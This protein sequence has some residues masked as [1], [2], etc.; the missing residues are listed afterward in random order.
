M[1]VVGHEDALALA[2][3]DD[4]VGA[5]GQRA[6]VGNEDAR[7]APTEGLA[8]IGN[9]ELGIAQ[10]EFGAISDRNTVKVGPGGIL[11]CH[12]RRKSDWEVGVEALYINSPVCLDV[13]ADLHVTNVVVCIVTCPEPTS[14]PSR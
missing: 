14:R 8:G 7:S 13:D 4:Q 5:S 6:G 10:V 9:A 3:G 1:R 2:A 11:D 12:I